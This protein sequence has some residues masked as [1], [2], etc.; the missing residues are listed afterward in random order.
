MA[1]ENC[2]TE[3]SQRHSQSPAVNRLIARRGSRR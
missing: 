3:S 1:I 2:L